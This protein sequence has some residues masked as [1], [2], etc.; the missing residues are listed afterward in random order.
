[1]KGKK[2][3]QQQFDTVSMD[4][5]FE[6]FHYFDGPQ[7]EVG[8]KIHMH[9]HQFIEIYFLLE[10]SVTYQIRDTFFSLESGDILLFHVN[11]PHCPIFENYQQRYERIVLRVAP[12]LLEELSS[13]QSDLSSGLQEEYLGVYR[14]EPEVRNHIRL[15]LSKLLL[16]QEDARFGSDLLARA[17]LQ[18][19]IVDINRYHFQR[20]EKKE[21]FSSSVKKS[22]MIEQI[23]QYIE[24]NLDKRLTVDELCEQVFLSKYYF[25]RFF[26]EMTGTS[27]YRYVMQKRLQETILLMESG[28]PPTTACLQCGF[29]DY[30]SFFRAFKKQFGFSPTQY[31]SASEE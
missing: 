13:E 24:E 28:T 3:H 25:M 30:S 2:Q 6:I 26:K 23:N 16:V 8:R 31:F 11:Q 19:L 15:L 22:Q 18:Q 5:D 1:M 14:F 7:L 29:G 20:N 21:E 10:G 27:V 12:R 4:K 17:Y 9:H